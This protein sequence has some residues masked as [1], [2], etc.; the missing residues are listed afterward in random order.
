MLNFWSV[1]TRICVDKIADHWV[2][3][4]N[5]IEVIAFYGP[6][7][8]DRAEREATSLGARL[9]NN[10]FT[11]DDAGTGDPLTDVRS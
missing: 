11:A 9:D 7:A 6:D 2:I 8:H 1:A 3:R 4:L 5:D 10:A